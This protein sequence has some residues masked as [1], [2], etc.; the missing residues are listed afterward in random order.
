VFTATGAVTAAFAACGRN[1]FRFGFCF[2]IFQWASVARLAATIIAVAAR[3]II[4]VRL[5]SVMTFHRTRISFAAARS[6]RRFVRNVRF[7]KCV[8]RHRQS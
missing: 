4:G 8:N 7:V 6:F 5:R 3:N 2:F 1:I